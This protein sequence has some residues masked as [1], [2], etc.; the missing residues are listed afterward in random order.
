[1]VKFRNLGAQAFVALVN[2]GRRRGV[3]VVGHAPRGLTLADAAEAG[4]RSLEHGQHLVL[5][6]SNVADSDRQDQYAA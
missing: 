3:P 1:M 5:G 4:M 6:M 2:E